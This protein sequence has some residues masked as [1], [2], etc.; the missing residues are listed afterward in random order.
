MEFGDIVFYS[1]LLP[2]LIILF[3]IAV[4]EPF[5]PL[6][7]AWI[8]SVIVIAYLIS[9]YKYRKSGTKFRKSGK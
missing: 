7:G 9:K 3:W 5:I 1:I 4:L 2:I 6:W 8:V